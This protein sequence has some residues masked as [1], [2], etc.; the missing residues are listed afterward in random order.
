LRRIVTRVLATTDDP[1]ALPLRLA[2]G[3][4]ILPH[5]M[6][7]VLGVFGGYGIAGTLSAFSSQLGIPRLLGVADML[8]EFLGGIALIA[9]FGTRIAA[10]AVGTVMAVAAL[11]VHLP[12]GFFMNWFGNQKG[13]GIEFHLLALGIA[14]ALV[15]KG[16]GRYSID[17]GIVQGRNELSSDS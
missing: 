14:I 7:K 10:L 17:R 1:A 12:N 8:A 13:E 11:L 3:I 2:L 5:G 9:G 15:I 16:G 4:M 6:Q